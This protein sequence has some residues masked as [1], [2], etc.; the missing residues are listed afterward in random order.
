MK[1]ALRANLRDESVVI[2]GFRNEIYLVWETVH[3]NAFVSKIGSENR[4]HRFSGCQYRPVARLEWFRRNLKFRCGTLRHRGET[5]VRTL[6]FFVN[7]F[8]SLLSKIDVS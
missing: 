2:N 3:H 6:V 8:Q 5:G 7:R 4:F 1:S